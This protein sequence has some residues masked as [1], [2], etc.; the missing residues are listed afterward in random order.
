MITIT[1]E[2]LKSVEEF[3]NNLQL[4]NEGKIEDFKSFTSIM[5]IYKE[6]LTETYMVRPR[7]PGGCTTLEQLKEINKIA[8]KYEG[9]QIRFTTRQDIQFHSVKLENLGE[10]LDDLIKAG[11]TTKAAGGDGVRNVA[12]SPLSGV[13]VDEVFDVTPYMK[14]V[15][16]YMLEDPKNLK[17]PRKYKIAFS[18]SSEDTVNATITDIGFIAKIVNGKRGFEVYGAGGLGGGP[19]VGIKL[20]DFIDHKDPLYYIQAM[21]QIFEREGDRENRHKARLRFVLQR[22]GEEAFREMFKAELDKVRTEKNLTLNINYNQ[23]QE[24]IGKIKEVN[25]K[26]WDKKYENRVINQKQEGCYTVYI[27]P[28]SGNMTTDKMD[29]ILNFLA[30]LDYE[31]S[32]RLTMTQ[33]FYVRDLKESDVEKLVDLTNEFSSIFNVDNSVVCAG[34]K[35]CKFGINNSQGLLN[36]II[37]TFKNESFEVKNALPQLLIS[38]CPNSCAQPQKGIIGLI[39]KR[40]R[41]EDGMIPAYSILFNGKAGPGVARF[42]ETYGEVAAKKIPNFFLEL[43]QLKVN[44]E[45]EDFVQFIENKETEIREIVNKYSTLESINENPDLYSDFE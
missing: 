1:K 9:T 27:H 16:N 19:R 24:D 38:G 20:E 18:N 41:T 23:E 29:I 2:I 26:Q 13:S 42:G 3:K 32:I 15:A 30:N 36:K 22:L 25:S 45:C 10:I 31:V 44:S 43:A 5:G 34:P 37:E 35:I 33:G 17:L 21:K 6:R 40:K 39:G 4:F 28:V 11:L 8:K 7:I 12:C 14:A